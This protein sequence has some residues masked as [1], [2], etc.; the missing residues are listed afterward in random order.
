MFYP[1]ADR[2]LVRGHL[3]QTAMTM[4]MLTF[5]NLIRVNT[6]TCRETEYQLRVKG[7]GATRAQT[8]MTRVMLT[9]A[10]LIR[11]NIPTCR[12]STS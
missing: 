4:V 5:A 7:S 2:V 1:P 10:N 6:P 3:A 9:F 11:V 8:A 12:Q